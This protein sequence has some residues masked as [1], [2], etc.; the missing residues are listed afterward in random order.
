MFPFWGHDSSAPRAPLQIVARTLG[1]RRAEYL[2]RRWT[3]LPLCEITPRRQLTYTHEQRLQR[4]SRS[5]RYERKFLFTETVERS[6]TRIAARRVAERIY[7]S[8]T[9]RNYITQATDIYIRARASTQKSPNA[10]RTLILVRGARWPQRGANH[11]VA[12]R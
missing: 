8:P 11:D 9:S 2:S 6:A 3:Y 7:V 5:E 1:A 10:V 12:R 4:G